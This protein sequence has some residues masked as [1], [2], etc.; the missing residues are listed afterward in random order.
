M[1]NDI[2]IISPAVK[3][4]VWRL[5]LR[6][7]PIPIFP[8]PEIYDLLVDL[9]RTRTDI[10]KQVEEAIDSLQQSSVLVSDLEKMLQERSDNLNNLLEEYNRYSNLAEMKEEE[11]EAVLNQLEITLGK[12]RGQDRWF[13]IVLNFIF[14]L[15]FFLAGIFLSDPVQTLFE[16][17]IAIVMT[18][19]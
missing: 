2:D 17:M 19:P 11:V 16:R 4:R 5:L 6:S 18:K 9:R 10:D 15:V 3:R 8:G 13:D 1:A 7:L 14:G 12:S